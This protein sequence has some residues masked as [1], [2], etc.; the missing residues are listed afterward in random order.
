MSI[1]STESPFLAGGFQADRPKE[2]PDQDC[3]GRAP[4]AANL[5]S[6]I[7]AWNQKDSLVIGLEGAWGSGKSTLKNFVLHYLRRDA[8]IPV[9]E[10]NPWQFSGDDRLFEEFAAAVSSALPSEGEGATERKQL[11]TKYSSY[12]A[13]GGKFAAALK[14]AASFSGIPG[15]TVVLDQATQA[16][17]A[18][19]GT[20]KDAVETME[21]DSK[22]LQSLKEKLTETF[23]QLD[24]PLLVVIDDIDRL[25]DE[26]VALVF[27]LVKA[28]ADFPNLVY[29]LL[30]DRH[31]VEKSLDRISSSKG[32]EYL[33]KIVQMPI[34]VPQ[35]QMQR[36]H[37]EAFNCLNRILAGIPKGLGHEWEKERWANLWVRGLS[38][39]FSDLRRVYRYS[40][41]CAFLLDNLKSQDCVEIDVMDF[42]AL[43]VLR[44]FEKAVYDKIHAA[45]QLL[46]GLETSQWETKEFEGLLTEILD[47]AKDKE[48]TKEIVSALFIKAKGKWEN[49][50][51]GESF[52][53]DATAKQRICSPDHFAKYFQMALPDGALSQSRVVEVIQNLDSLEALKGVFDDAIRSETIVPLLQ[54]L[55]HH[56]ALDKQEDP[57]PYLLALC[58]SVDTFP[59]KRVSVGGGLIDVH[60]SMFAM[61]AV[62]RCCDSRKTAEQKA[63]LLENVILKSEG[64]YMPADL[65]Y[66]WQRRTEKADD[67]LRLPSLD[68]ERA[69]RLRTHVL[70]RLGEWARAGRLIKHGLRGSLINLWLRWQPEACREW[71]SSQLRE[72]EPAQRLVS[73]QLRESSSQTVGSVYKRK[74]EYFDY[75]WMESLAPW[76]EWKAAIERVVGQ[77]PTSEFSQRIKTALEQSEERKAKGLKSTD[78]AYDE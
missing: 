71:I 59:E 61:W 31:Y 8:Q 32:T 43:E 1:E 48:A 29:L 36:V 17:D 25:T 46:T 68:S 54:A 76:D 41:S 64:L 47:S 65:L 75:E 69:E 66:T 57:L 49:M 14:L 24:R 73:S 10:F 74:R 9:V 77:E 51:Y 23:R 6:K 63:E 38:S 21:G 2:Q 52:M 7:S 11:W 33:Q 13:F 55:Q 37:E 44:I 34:P 45:G 70:N 72:V 40:N 27:R 67:D 35:P 62:L 58:D 28:N 16:L 50:G 20:V 78:W 42:L 30:Y 5:A 12:L 26:E 39:Y 60:P 15:A 53:R 22:S 19:G 4:F 18:I 3:L 56:D